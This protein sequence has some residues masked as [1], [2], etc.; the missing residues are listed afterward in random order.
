MPNLRRRTSNSYFAALQPLG[1]L[2]PFS[3]SPTCCFWSEVVKSTDSLDIS[4]LA[5][6]FSYFFPF[7]PAGMCF[8]DP[9]FAEKA[10]RG[11][12]SRRRRLTFRSTLR[13]QSLPLSPL[14]SLLSSTAILLTPGRKSNQAAS[15]G[16]SRPSRA[17]GD[18][19]LSQVTS[20]EAA[21]PQGGN[22]GVDVAL[23]APRP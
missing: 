10:A 20:T 23:S 16:A 1:P 4:C 19:R 12:R 8:C 15:E 14:P 13:P 21:G 22:G 2:F 9:Y 11:G 6:G 17:P 5:R 3:F 18:L 7:F